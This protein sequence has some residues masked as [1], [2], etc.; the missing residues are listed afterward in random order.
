MDHVEPQPDLPRHRLSERHLDALCTGGGG[1]D[2]VRQLWHTQRSRRLLL[3]HAVIEAASADARLLG[4]LP[5]ADTARDVL[6][7][8]EESAPAEFTDLLLHPQIGNWAAYTLRRHRGG[9]D[10]Q[11]PIWAD[12]GALHAVALV[13][14]ARAGLRWR[15]RLPARSGRVMLPSLGMAVLPAPG[16]WCAVEAECADGRVRIGDPDQGVTVRLDSTEDDVP[17][18]WG[19]R[20]LSAGTGPGLRVLLDDVDPYRELADPVEPDRLDDAAVARWSELLAGAWRLLHEQQPDTAESIAAGVV[21][22]VPLPTSD[23]LETRSASTG[24]AFGSVMV[25]TPPDEATLAVSLVHEFQHIKLGG[26]MHLVPLTTGRDEQTRYAPWRDDPRPLGGLLQGIYAFVGI[27]AFLRDYRLTCTGAQRRDAD[28]EYAYARAQVREALRG[29]RRPAGLTDWGERLLGRLAERVEPW[30]AEPLPV[31]S[32]RAA[33]LIALGHRSGWRIRHLRPP[34]E[35]VRRLTLAWVG[36]R[37]VQVDPYRP[38]VVAHPQQRW[39]QGLLLL[40][41]RYVAGYPLQLGPRLR[42]LDVSEADI[43]LVRGDADAA[44]AGY[45][46]RLAADADDLNAWV[47]LGLTTL[48]PTSDSALP[49]RD[50]VLLHRPE[51][52][53]AVYARAAERGYRPDALRLTAWLDELTAGVNPLASD[54]G[55]PR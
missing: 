15:T 36:G 27:A 11:A 24:E 19:L 22:L 30:L 34:A 55:R 13:A 35:D 45:L 18:W 3:L 16:R 41:R 17:G 43:A 8:A 49:H 37:G 38:A 29:L 14:A 52:V 46:A 51:L 10:A 12:F 1:P 54:A 48:G 26:L 47:G 21:S 32:T 6:V 4:P 33:E 7:R 39:S 28:L 20:R 5:P 9:A 23:D 42:A 40:V 44:R 53:R 25:S 31:E 2:L 50:S